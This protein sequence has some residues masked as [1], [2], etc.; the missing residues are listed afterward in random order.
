MSKLLEHAKAFRQ[1]ISNVADAVTDEVAL[2][3][4]EV[5]DEWKLNTEYETG[6]RVRDN[7]LLYKCR[8][9]HLSLYKPSEVPA[10]WEVIDISHAG[11]IDDPIPYSVGM[12]I[13]KDKYYIEDDI[14]YLCVRDSGQPLHA[15][16]KD[17]VPH[18]FE[19]VE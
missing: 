12:E 9:G 17:L 10:L 7:G 8:Q 2:A 16:A 11:T 5:F 14:K 15:K 1:K 19:V 18:Y 13:F 4:K 3:N 6:K